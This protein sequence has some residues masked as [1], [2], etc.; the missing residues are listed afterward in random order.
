MLALAAIGILA[1]TGQAQENYATWSKNRTITINTT[2]TGG[3][4]NV[5]GTVTNFPVLVRLTSAQSDVFANGGAKGASIRFT[6]VDGTTRLAHQRERWDSAGQV[7][8]FWVKV[9][10]VAGN[11]TTTIKLYYGK[12]GA[13]DSSKGSAVFDTANGFRGVWHM[14][15]DSVT[16]EADATVNALTLT[17]SD[18]PPTDTIGAIGKARVFAGVP[19]AAATRQYFVGL[20]TMDNPAVDGT[21][22]LPHTVSAWAYARTIVATN[23]R[24]N[25]IFNK[26]DNQYCLQI[27]GGNGA[28]VK[29][30]ES[31]V[32]TSTWRQTPSNQVAVAGAWYFITGTWSGGDDNTTGTGQIYVNGVL[33][34]TLSLDIGTDNPTRTYNLFVGANPNSNSATTAPGTT[35]S[36]LANTSA[37]PRFWNGYLDEI[38]FSRTVR[39]AD[40]VKLN[41]ETQ[42]A[43][44]TA[45]TV[46]SV[47]G[48]SSGT[49][50][51]SPSFLIRNA[52]SGFVFTVPGAGRV[53]VLDIKGREVW[54][55]T[56]AQPADVSWNGLGANGARLSGA[57]VAR[58]TA[59]VNGV[60]TT[61]AQR[62]F[63]IVK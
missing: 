35:S 58:V 38:T 43:G 14:T 29:K 10:S 20:N 23:N 5:A 24:G 13:A 59:R 56:S 36:L 1:V 52:G 25:S 15:A 54:S 61:V 51:W 12:V 48:I 46:G 6:A 31:A 49:P 28:T 32:Y 63:S 37:N 3:G 42:K 17:A 34:S 47:V 7:A 60:E 27:Y 21:T 55:H 9:P 39:N 41:Y 11:A 4:A 30:W 57:F 33:D 19:G 26:G 40:W 44:A 18:T 50:D 45:V 2:A 16:T 22:N 62:S 8:E 53:T